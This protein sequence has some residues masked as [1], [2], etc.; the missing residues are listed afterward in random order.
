M[1]GEQLDKL[2][3]G[4]FSNLH[5]SSKNHAEFKLAA[6]SLFKRTS[7]TELLDN[8]LAFFQNVYGPHSFKL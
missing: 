2:I 6:K 5:D 8:S 4:H 7:E 3:L 1:V